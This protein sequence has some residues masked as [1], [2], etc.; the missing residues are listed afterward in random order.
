MNAGNVGTRFFLLGA[1]A[2]AWLLG[3]STEARASVTPEATC[4][5]DTLFLISP[6]AVTLEQQVVGRQGLT[7]SWRDLNL[8]ESTCYVLV[9]TENLEYFVD[10]VGGYGDQV[11]RELVFL[12][13]STG[14][15]GSSDNV[16]VT[17]SN[18]GSTVNGA[19]SGI[20][21]L[22]NNGGIQAYDGSPED[23]W[24]KRNQGLPMYWRQVNV[25]ALDAGTDGFMVAAFSAGQSLTA[26]FRGLYV[27]EDGSWGRIAE[28]LF[29]D[30]VR[31]NVVSVSPLNNDHFAVGTESQGVYVT[32]DGGLTFEQFAAN[33]DP[34]FDPAP[35]SVRVGALE[36]SAGRLW[37]FA[38]NFGLFYSEAPW[39]SF[40]RS[41]LLVDVDLDDPELGT[42]L[43]TTAY[44]IHVNPSNTDHVLICLAFNGVFQTFDG[45][46]TWSDTYGDLMVPD[47]EQEGL[48]SYSADA[49]LVDPDNPDILIAGM[50]SRGL[51][52]SDDGG[53][54][55]DRVGAD[56]GPENNSLLREVSLVAS[57]GTAGRYY[58]MMDQ[59]SLLVSNDYGENWDFLDTQPL[60][61]K[62]IVMVPDPDGEVIVGTWGGGIYQ[63]GIPLNL[64]DTYD[65]GTSDF[66]RDL[67]LG[68]SIYFDEVEAGMGGQVTSGEQFTLKCQ[69]F[70]GW[71]V[72]RAPAYDPDSMTLIGLFDRVNPESCIEGYCGNVNFEIVPECYNSKRAACFNF[73]T[74]DTVRFFDEEIY[75]GFSY[76]YAV[77]SYD[78]GNT[79]DTS[80]VDNR[81]TAV[82]SPRYDADGLSPFE[83][84]G[85]RTFIELNED[86]SAAET[87]DEIYVYPNPL[88]ADEGLP[89]Q[90]GETVV[91]TNLPPESRVRVFTPAGDDVINLGPDAMHGGN[92]YWQ[93]RNH[94]NQSVSAG[95]YLYK[96]E[97]PSREDYWGR[98]VIIR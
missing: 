28:D 21:N 9:G 39:D 58:C 37:A 13:E 25:P 46:L 77:T 33:M 56:V 4:A 17:W 74:P 3:I 42:A 83:G 92:I 54:T 8:E 79:A 6:E 31:I 36:W 10:V 40:T 18:G 48:W 35:T 81:K 15:I 62:S 89:G 16:V 75:N 65:S 80:P 66:L 88:R 14:Q 22:S 76:Y 71:A 85:N 60:V 70:Q 38:A 95:V 94:E 51:F 97:M 90:E 64:S 24:S 27:Y 12:S 52:R 53:Q 2:L 41:D 87:G 11:D 57:P 43:P 49:V 72:W 63:A 50:K 29:T 5:N 78:Y 19:L 30:S 32:L 67:D 34:S 93:T 68:L 84:A 20:L 44:Q 7:I 47:P 96:V 61:A 73:D 86:P 69:T 45:G 91:F 23:P 82:Y 1:V 55:W 26:E 59:H 98:L